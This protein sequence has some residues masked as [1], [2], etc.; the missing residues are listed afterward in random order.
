MAKNLEDIDF[1]EIETDMVVALESED[2][3]DAIVQYPVPLPLEAARILK[4]RFEDNHKERY[5]IWTEPSLPWNGQPRNPEE[6]HVIYLGR[7]G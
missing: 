3:E 2:D 6:E 7:K 4:N 1:E 5:E